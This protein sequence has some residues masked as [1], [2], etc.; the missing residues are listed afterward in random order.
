M[1]TDCED[2]LRRLTAKTGLLYARTTSSLL[3]RNFDSKCFPIRCTCA[4]TTIEWQRQC[5]CTLLGTHREV[6]ISFLIAIRLHSRHLNTLIRLFSSIWTW[7]I[8]NKCSDSAYISLPFALTCLSSIARS[9]FLIHRSWSIVLS[10]HRQT[11]AR[12]HDSNSFLQFKILGEI[13]YYENAKLESTDFDLIDCINRVMVNAI[14]LDLSYRN[15][16]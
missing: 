2:W 9:C 4:R 5:L 6:S 15:T 10:I 8:V 7:F 13:H 11:A 3:G 12:T 16:F 14:K 1:K